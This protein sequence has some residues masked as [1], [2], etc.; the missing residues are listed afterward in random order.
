VIVT[1]SVPPA[2]SHFTEQVTCGATT[3]QPPKVPTEPFVIA[4]TA[5]TLAATRPCVPSTT[6]TSSARVEA[7]LTT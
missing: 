3:V 2:F 6:R 7:V 4:W 5:V 1:S